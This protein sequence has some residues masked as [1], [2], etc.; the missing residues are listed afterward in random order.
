MLVRSL[1][2]K[3]GASA[4]VTGTSAGLFGGGV[5]SVALSARSGASACVTGTSACLFEGRVTGVVTAGGAAGTKSMGWDGGSGKFSATVLL[6]PR[7]VEPLEP[8]ADGVAT[9]A[10]L[11]DED[12]S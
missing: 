3:S 6:W 9:G 7:D 12:G 10:A 5:E 4:C 1:S 2:A 11:L 8:L